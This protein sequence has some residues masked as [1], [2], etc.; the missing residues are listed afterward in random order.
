VLRALS[1]LCPISKQHD[2]CNNAQRHS[3]CF[4]QGFIRDFALVWP[5]RA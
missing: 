5:K 2:R 4:S 1:R 3:D